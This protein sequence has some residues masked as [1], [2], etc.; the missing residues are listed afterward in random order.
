MILPR[1]DRVVLRPCLPRLD[2]P[3]VDGIRLRPR[4]HARA[5][6][7]VL[8]PRHVPALVGAADARKELLCLDRLRRAVVCRSSTNYKRTICHPPSSDV[9]GTDS[10]RLGKP[11]DLLHLDDSVLRLFRPADDRP[12]PPR[13]SGLVSG[14]WRAMDRVL[15]TRPG[16]FSTLETVTTR[17]GA[18]PVTEKISISLTGVS[19]ALLI[20][21][22]FRAQETQ[23]SVRR[24]HQPPPG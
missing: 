12:R 15:Q 3:A 17:K 20:P 4:C 21:L 7:A 13:G 16:V 14:V 23:R 18:I 9:R 5:W 8:F 1:L 22:Y 10:G 2:S 19:E 6:R 24:R 11:A